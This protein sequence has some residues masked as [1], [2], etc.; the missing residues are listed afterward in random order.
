MMMFLHC[1]RKII[2]QLL[3]ISSCQRA[4]SDNKIDSE[5]AEAALLSFCPIPDPRS[6]ID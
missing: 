5:K 4:K 3:M 6:V 1:E 2:L